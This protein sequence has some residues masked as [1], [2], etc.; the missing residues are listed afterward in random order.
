MREASMGVFG[1]GEESLTPKAQKNDNG[2][3]IRKIIIEHPDD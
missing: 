1:Q 2:N 3:A